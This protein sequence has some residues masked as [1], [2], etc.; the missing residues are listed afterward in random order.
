MKTEDILKIKS[1]DMNDVMSLIKEAI[2]EMERHH[3]Y[4]WHHIYPDYET[5]AS[6]IK[7]ETIFGFYCD[8]EL[9]GIVVLNENQSPEYSNIG[10]E[11]NNCIPLVMHRLC[12]RPKFQ[13]QG[14]A[15]KLLSFSEQWAI[16]HKYKSI[17]LDAFSGNPLAL[18]LY[19]QNGYKK[20]GSVKFRKGDFWCY[21]KI[22]IPVKNSNIKSE[23]TRQVMEITYWH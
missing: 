10:W 7:T 1:K 17:R 9:A 11:L 13:N 5:I 2:S 12:I 19:N 23:L 3:I 14:I 20:R 22:L 16:N 18:N 15:K 21:E 8:A 6:D 4:Q